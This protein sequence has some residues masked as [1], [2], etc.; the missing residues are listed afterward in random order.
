MFESCRVFRAKR[1]SLVFHLHLL[2]LN[3]EGIKKNIL[4]FLIEG[5]IS[6][7]FLFFFLS[8]HLYVTHI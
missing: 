3:L 4:S 6:A 8:S 5:L 2:S 1:K 7:L